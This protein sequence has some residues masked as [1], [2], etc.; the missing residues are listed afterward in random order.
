MALGAS[1]SDKIHTIFRIVGKQSYYS[2]LSLNWHKEMLDI[3]AQQRRA[4]IYVFGP[5]SRKQ[6]A[7][8][9][10]RCCANLVF[11]WASFPGT[12]LT[13]ADTLADFLAFTVAVMVLYILE[14]QLIKL[15][16]VGT[17]KM[18]TWNRKRRSHFGAFKYKWH[19]AFVI[20]TMFW[21]TD[22][23]HFVWISTFFC[24]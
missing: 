5:G 4:P 8:S 12:S 10:S 24:A 14:Y 9:R 16:L 22:L 20:R 3:W 1:C 7:G 18:L 21:T 17:V 15:H 23:L 13:Q 19:N 2:W 6:E 11:W